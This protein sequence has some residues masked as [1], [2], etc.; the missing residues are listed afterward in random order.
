MAAPRPPREEMEPP[1]N[2]PPSPRP[3]PLPPEEREER[4]GEA[5]PEEGRPREDRVGRGESAVLE[6]VW[7]SCRRTGLEK[8]Y[9]RQRTI[10]VD[11]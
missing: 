6:L 5:R 4:P 2:A 1:P 3:K 9:E 10:L 11:G 8:S 7:V